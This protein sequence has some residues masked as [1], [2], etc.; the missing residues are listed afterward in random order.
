[1]S[2][3]PLPNTVLEFQTKVKIWF[4]GSPEHDHKNAAPEEGELVLQMGLSHGLPGSPNFQPA[5]R[6][7]LLGQEMVVACEGTCRGAHLP[8]AVQSEAQDFWGISPGVLPS[9]RA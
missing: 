4:L 6:E 5:S 2:P 7:A 8:L 3:A 1:M 9:S